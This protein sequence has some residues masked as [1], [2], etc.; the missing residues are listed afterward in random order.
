MKVIKNS[1]EFVKE[2]KLLYLSNYFVWMIIILLP[3]LESILMGKIIYNI[4]SYNLSILLVVVFVALGFLKVALVYFGGILDTMV[5]YKVINKLHYSMIKKTMNGKSENYSEIINIVEND[6]AV[7]GEYVS[8]L[9]DFLCHLCYYIIAIT[10]MISINAF[11]AGIVVLFAICSSLLHRYLNKK[12]SKYNAL[13]RQRSITITKLLENSLKNK[14]SL[15]S[16][17]DKIGQTKY[18]SA[19]LEYNK[20][21]RKEKLIIFFINQIGSNSINIQILLIFSIIPFVTIEAYEIV[22]LITFLLLGMAS[23]D[24]FLEIGNLTTLVKNSYNK[25][26]SISDYKWNNKHSICKKDSILFYGT[27]ADN[28]CLWETDNDKL[29]KVLKFVNIYDELVDRDVYNYIVDENTTTLSL[30]QKYRI[31]LARA[32]YNAK[33][34]VYYEN[35]FE[36]IDKE[37]VN[38]ILHNMNT[39]S[40]LKFISV[41]ESNN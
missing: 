19:V 3:I 27:I 31:I 34:S 10:I 11:I 33:D 35:I 30:G 32:I 6:S 16:S 29:E 4:S 8:L 26:D 38:I 25:I 40:D 23:I 22:S 15:L 17:Q 9:I 28:V 13:K 39:Q 24:I 36:H 12:L 18:N 5:R 21:S 2:M 37:S 41:E 7:V 1:L 14:I 20:F